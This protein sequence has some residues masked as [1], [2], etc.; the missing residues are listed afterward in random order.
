[1]LCPEVL[2]VA[3]KRVLR[4]RGVDRQLDRRI[5]ED[6][7]DQRLGCG[8]GQ[9]VRLVAADVAH[10]RHKPGVIL[11]ATSLEI[12][13]IHLPAPVTTLQRSTPP[14]PAR[15]STSLGPATQHR[16]WRTRRS[17]GERV[18]MV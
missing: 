2:R 13:K 16:N 5:G 10:L 15:G 4:P 12:H 6:P 18:E 3:H 8:E 17:E 11:A 1:V 9:L 14:S 7:A